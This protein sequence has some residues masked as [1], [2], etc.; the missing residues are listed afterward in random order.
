[1]SNMQAFHEQLS[2]GA[3]ELNAYQHSLLQLT[4]I[5]R[6]QII[7]LTEDLTWYFWATQPAQ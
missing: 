4:H 1:M 7:S 5:S 2:S 6:V 3:E